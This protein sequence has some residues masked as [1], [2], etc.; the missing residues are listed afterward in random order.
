MLGKLLKHEISYYVKRFFPFAIIMLVISLILCL[1]RIIGDIDMEESLISMTAS[2]MF[3]VFVMLL[4][5]GYMILLYIVMACPYF[6]G[7][8]RFHKNMFTDEG[9]LTNTLPVKSW[10]HI[11]SKLIG[12][13]S[14]YVIAKITLYLSVFFISGEVVGIQN[15]ISID[16]L[17]FDQIFERIENDFIIF[18]ISEI[19]GIITFIAF[20]LLCYMVEAIRNRLNSNKGFAYFIVFAAIFAHM[21]IYAIIVGYV[22]AMQEDVATPPSLMFIISVIY[23]IIISLLMFFITNHIIGKKLNLE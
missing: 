13:I 20:I 14:C 16:S 18:I 23:Y 17:F 7:I 12:T 2:D 19:N 22:S 4:L 6:M 8:S 5:M 9:Y 15:L 1:C 11:V 21:M 10:E 3:S